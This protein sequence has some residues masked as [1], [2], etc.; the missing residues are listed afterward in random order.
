MN[1][2]I[3][4][5]HVVKAVKLLRRYKET[6][7][8]VLPEELHAYLEKQILESSWYEEEVHRELLRAVAAVLERRGLVP[9]GSD[10]WEFIGRDAAEQDIEGVYRNILKRGAP[11]ATLQALA[12]LWHLRWSSGKAEVTIHEPRHATS[13][14]TGYE[15]PSE[16]WCRMIRSYQVRFLELAGATSVK[17]REIECL[18]RGDE[19]CLRDLK[20]TS[21]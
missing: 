8:E 10:P 3:K 16:D 6:A 11:A 1:E 13:V 15:M 17:T 14:L 18:A 19:R 20:W 4:G 7:R 12:R 5:S 2:K 21:A 9:A